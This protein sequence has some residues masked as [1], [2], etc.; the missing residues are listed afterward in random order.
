MPPRKRAAAAPAAAAVPAT[1]VGAPRAES[2]LRLIKAQAAAATKGDDVNIEESA[3]QAARRAR[4]EAQRP[5][6]NDV[7]ALLCADDG[8]PLQ[9]KERGWLTKR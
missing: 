6:G 5:V 1:E 4:A 3:A 7:C 9:A 2:Q 8:L